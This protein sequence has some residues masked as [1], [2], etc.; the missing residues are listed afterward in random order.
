MR[1]HINPV[2]VASIERIAGCREQCLDIPKAGD[3]EL[4]WLALDYLPA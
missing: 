3:L 2:A 1:T 4:F